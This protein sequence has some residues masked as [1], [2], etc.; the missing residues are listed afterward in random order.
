[1]I[2]AGVKALSLQGATKIT[3][4]EAVA[5]A[6]EMI[7]Q[8]TRSDL[9][10]PD[11][12]MKFQYGNSS[13]YLAARIKKDRP[14]IVERIEAGEFRSIRAAAKEAGFVREASPLDLLKRTWGKASHEEREA[15]LAW[16]KG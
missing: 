6:P 13:S 16:V 12:V 1:M 4:A 7:G 15:F 11:N 3:A 14:D 5:A 8:G 10:L 2:V 9:E